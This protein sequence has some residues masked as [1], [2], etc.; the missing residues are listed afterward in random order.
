MRNII[1]I[2]PFRRV[3]DFSQVPSLL[4]VTWFKMTNSDYST[5]MDISA[6]QIWMQRRINSGLDKWPWCYRED[7]RDSDQMWNLRVQVQ[8]VHQ[9]HRHYPQSD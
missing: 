9:P 2:S 4:F 7:N 1:D 8:V 6:D 5:L 3:V